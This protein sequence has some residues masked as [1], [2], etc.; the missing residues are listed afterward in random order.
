MELVGHFY[1]DTDH[2]QMMLAFRLFA[3]TQ[4]EETP[5]LQ[6]PRNVL[7]EMG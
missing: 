2:E 5:V 4:Q 7:R 6:R 1:W 3:F